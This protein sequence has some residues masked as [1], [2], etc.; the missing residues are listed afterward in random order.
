[1]GGFRLLDERGREGGMEEGS[2]IYLLTYLFNDNELLLI[3]SLR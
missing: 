3:P 1:M 2:F